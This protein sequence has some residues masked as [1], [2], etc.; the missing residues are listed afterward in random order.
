MTDQQRVEAA[1]GDLKCAALFEDIEMWKGAERTIKDLFENYAKHYA[2][3][4][5]IRSMLTRMHVLIHNDITM[6][7]QCE[8]LSI[9]QNC[10]CQKC[11]VGRM[12]FNDRVMK[13]YGYAQ[14]GK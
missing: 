7:G 6:F 12:D 9:G 14:V 1:L 4:D 5:M 2:T 10:N 8:M 13:E 11:Q 3:P